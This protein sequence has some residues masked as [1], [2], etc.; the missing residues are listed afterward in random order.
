[1]CVACIHAHAQ[2][3]CQ[4]CW[5][6]LLEWS[7]KSELRE[8]D[9]ISASLYTVLTSWGHPSVYAVIT[10]AG[11]SESAH[12]A[13]IWY[14]CD[15]D[16]KVASVVVVPSFLLQRLQAVILDPHNLSCRFVLFHLNTVRYVFDDVKEAK[17]TISTG[18]HLYKNACCQ[19]KF[20]E[21]ASWQ[22]LWPRYFS[23]AL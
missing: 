16:C 20:C 14:L 5:P 9:I 19:V 10:V 18:E 23:G 8:R 21:V 12:A 2:S 17:I 1:M 6:R 22:L 3:C 7:E 15:V 11:Q 13:I 4:R